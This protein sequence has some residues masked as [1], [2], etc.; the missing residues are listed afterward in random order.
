MGMRSGGYELH[1]PEQVPIFSTKTKIFYKRYRTHY[2]IYRCDLDTLD[3][4]SSDNIFIKNIY[5]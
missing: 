2:K 4:D 3:S 5:M 1:G